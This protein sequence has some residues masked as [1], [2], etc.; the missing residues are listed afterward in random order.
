MFLLLE[1][2]KPRVY[3]HCRHENDCSTV[4]FKLAGGGKQEQ[5]RNSSSQLSRGDLCFSCLCEY[6]VDRLKD[7]K[8]LLLYFFLPE[9]YCSSKSRVLF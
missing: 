7:G 8:T 5:S 1:C 9:V 2:E 3:P 6:S 4:Q